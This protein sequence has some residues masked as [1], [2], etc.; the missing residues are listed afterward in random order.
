MLSS[1]VYAKTVDELCDQ[2]R[3]FDPEADT[4]LIRR[5]YD[6]AEEAH[7]GQKRATGEPYIIHLVF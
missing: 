6:F 1:F 5:A 2:V 4:A 7:R 3:A